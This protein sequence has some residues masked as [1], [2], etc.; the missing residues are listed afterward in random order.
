MKRIFLYLNS[1]K[2]SLAIASLTGYCL[3]MISILKLSQNNANIPI[4]KNIFQEKNDIENRSRAIT[5]NYFL[6]P[7]KNLRQFIL[8]PEQASKGDLVDFERYYERVTESFPQLAEGF[9]LLGFCQ[10][11]LGKTKEA[12]A[13]YQKAIEVNPNLFGAHYSL[14]IILFNQK[15][16]AKAVLHLEFARRLPIKII[17]NN[18][19]TS[20]IYQQVLSETI[21]SPQDIVG[22]IK[23]GHEH[24]Y[25]LLNLSYQHLN[26]LKNKHLSPNPV[27][28]TD[29][30]RIL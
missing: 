3:L 20:K 19:A 28:A 2:L 23:K 26:P 8:A 24:I 1:I 30:L 22:I 5:L 29:T 18:I 7:F 27:N 11:N 14:G 10:Y 15:E 6:P 9:H 13:S 12:I 4:L 16:Y 17:L 25:E 21:I